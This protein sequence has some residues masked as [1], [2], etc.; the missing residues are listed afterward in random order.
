M[1]KSIYDES[2][3][4]WYERQGD[5]Y[6]PCLS[7]P[8]DHQPTG[9]WGCGAPVA[10]SAEG[11]STDRAGR[12]DQR[13]LRYIKE[14]REGS[15]IGLLLSG[16]LNNYLEDVDRQ[17]QRQLDT[18]CHADS[19][20]C[21]FRFKKSICTVFPVHRNGGTEQPAVRLRKPT[22]APNEPLHPSG[23]PQADPR[24]WLPLCGSCC[25]RFT[26]LGNILLL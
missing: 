20:N 24:A 5:Y 14:H 16:K 22:N 21:R 10:T 19:Q 11:R 18:T 25:Q 6:I 1:E 2:N 17:A 7:L 26:V 15:Y 4:L 23:R 3:G 13:Y 9:L 8:G 12:R